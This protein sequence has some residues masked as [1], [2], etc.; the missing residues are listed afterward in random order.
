[1]I[2]LSNQLLATVTQYAELFTKIPED[3]ASQPLAPGKWS[4]KQ[5]LGHLI[6]SASNNHQRFIRAQLNPHTDLPG[7]QQEEWVSAN[8]YALESWTELTQLW[9]SYNHHLAHILARMP[10]ETLSH[11]VTLD[12]KPP[13]TIQTIAED[14][15][16]HVIHHLEQMKVG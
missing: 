6:D 2:Q 11:T 1:M 8:G 7:Y 14:Y 16:R 9:K 13:M 5:I 12:T 10:D 4:R 15:Y 3:A